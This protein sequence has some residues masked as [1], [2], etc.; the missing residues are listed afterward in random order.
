MSPW[1]EE[2]LKGIVIVYLIRTRRVGLPIDAGIAGFAARR[3][4]HEG[5]GEAEL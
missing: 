2:A 5:A 1:I 3:I 4:R